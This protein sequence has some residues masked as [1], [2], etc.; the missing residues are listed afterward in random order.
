M[1]SA[2]GPARRGLPRPDAAPSAS[3]A[4]LAPERR[5][6]SRVLAAIVIAAGVLVLAAAIILF[7]RWLLTL[8]GVQQFLADH[9]GT[10][11]VPDATP[12]GLPAWLGWQHFL[13]VFFL[14]LIVRTG[15]QV[16][17]ERRPPVHVTPRGT[18]RRV[19]LASW[20]HQSVDVLWM[21]NGV[22]YIVLLFTTGQWLRIVPVSWEVFPNA[23]SAG[24][25]YAAL[26]W[27]TEDGWVFYNA[28]QQ[29]SYF[30]IVFVAAP[31]AAITGF[32]MSVAWPS[33]A[34]LLERI[35]PLRVARRI[36]FP[37]MIVFVAFTVV[38]VL[39]VLA[40]GALRNLNHMYAA[41]DATDWV[42]A[43]VF[44]ASL[45]VIAGAVIA[46]RPTLLTPLARLFGTVGR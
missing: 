37:V 7:S 3:V 33:R 17:T 1:T 6:R 35:L 27:P 16:R 39:L 9:P 34:R 20:F 15:I 18:G 23:V 46:V 26:A 44:A 25:R 32:R 41:R 8:G 24:L 42:G 29:L 10:S 11:P 36:H 22:L 30:V 31:L 45:L 5:R 28:L 14:A 13:N 43:G 12:T 21:A 40:T 38:H 2:P 4:R 19:S